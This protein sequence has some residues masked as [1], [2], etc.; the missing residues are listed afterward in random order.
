[1][2]F[3][4]KLYSPKGW[5]DSGPVFKNA[6]P[7][8]N[9]YNKINRK[10]NT[11]LRKALSTLFLVFLLLFFV[12]GTVGAGYYTWLLRY[13]PSPD[14]MID[15]Q[16]KQSTKI[17]DRDGKALLYEVYG[18]QNR[19]MLSLDQISPY[20]KYATLSAEDRDFYN[21]HGISWKGIIRSL[22]SNI[23]KGTKVSGSTITQQ[24]VKNAILTPE[25]TYTRKLKEIILTVQLENKFSK[26]EILKMYLNEIS[27]GSVTYGIGSASRRFFGKDANDLDIAEAAF[28]A[29]IP[30]APTFYSPYGQNRDGLTARYKYVIGAMAEQNYITKD[31]AEAAKKEDIFG[32]LQDNKVFI[33]APH[34]VFYVKDILSQMFGEQMVEQGGLKVIT[35]LDMERQKA[36]ETALSD[37][38]KNV[39]SYN[40]SN[41]ALTAMDPKTG[42][43]VAMAGSFDYFDKSIDGNVNV[44]LRPRQQGSSFKPIVYATGLSRGYTPN[45]IL[46]DVVTT[47]PTA[48]EEGGY[49]PHDYDLKE[50][51]PISVRKALAGSLNIPAVKMIYLAG[52]NNVLDMA[53][54]LG[55]T[56]LKDR[57]R[58]GLSLVLGGGEVKLLEHVGAYTAFANEGAAAKPVAILRVEDSSGR[59]LYE[60]KPELKPVLD[61]EVARQM[62]GI[63]SDNA[64]REYI[65]GAKNYLNLGFPAG[66]KTGTTNDYHDAWTIGFTPELVAGVWVGN[67]NNKEMKNKADGSV[68]AAPIWNQFMKAA[69]RDKT[70]TFTEPKPVI[71]GKPILDGEE[72]P[73][74]V[75]KIDKASGKLA[76]E[77]TPASFIIEEKT[78][79]EVHNILYYVNK[80]NPQGPMPQNPASD[81]YYN[82]WET[83]VQDWALKNNI[84]NQLPPSGYDDL[85]VPANKP[86]VS[87]VSPANNSSVGRSFSAAVKASAPRGVSRVEYFIDNKLVLTARTGLFYGTI[88]MPSDTSKGFHSLKTVAYDDIDNSNEHEIFINFT[89]GGS[90]SEDFSWV[91][92]Q[93]NA[94]ISSFPINISFNASA[95]KVSF[96]YRNMSDN[97]YYKIGDAENP[98]GYASVAWLGNGVEKGNYEI[99]AV[100]QDDFGTEEKTISVAVQ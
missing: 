65:F 62:N 50:R 66:V 99:K 48:V 54:S 43:V 70:K 59:V 58:Y 38:R 47:F 52:I 7:G 80:D 49:T 67:N 6:S 71:T 44:A 20:V 31:Q 87:I 13:L 37:N 78:Y 17:Y 55:Y 98:N 82:G 97:N 21:H 18:D 92:P 28:L 14:R 30:Q 51:G 23:F 41:A 10:K 5:R 74:S 90:A 68:V 63:L 96:W 1:M 79:K 4:Q 75:I 77:F 16:L 12:G 8:G 24:F 95:T 56:T 26:D 27:Y 36:A 64:A 83:A 85:H 32:K 33:L 88:I 72:M 45:T 61:P 53:D 9:N 91:S 86:Q 34:F 29:S 84:I 40:G 2:S 46:Y 35:S 3:A 94:V 73:G 69:V 42:E 39:N 19:T 57:S 81:P 11:K 93:N 22:L 60:A 15:R 89:S 100:I 25:K 76:T